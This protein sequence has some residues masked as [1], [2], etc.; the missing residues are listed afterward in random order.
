MLSGVG[1]RNVLSRLKIP[2]VSDLPVGLNLQDHIYPGGLHYIVDEEHES[3]E[4]TYMQRKIQKP[5]NFFKYLING[6]GPLAS[7]GGL[8]GLGFIKT[9]YANQ[10]LD[11]PDFEIHLVCACLSSDDGRTFR[12]NMGITEEVWKRVY[13]PHVGKQCFSLFPVI[14]RPKSVGF[15][16]LRSANAYDPPIIQPNYLTHPHDIKTM[17]EAMKITMQV[18]QSPPMR[19]LG[20]KLIDNVVPGLSLYL[21]NPLTPSTQRLRTLFP[22]FGRILGLF[23]QNSDAHHLSSNRNL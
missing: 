2:V 10:S 14:L 1:P 8:E 23:G 15:L 13:L 12:H 3:E 5:K 19:A 16:T 9:K 17:V 6:K 18:G 4:Q 11:L 21:S 7:T 20:A 22:A